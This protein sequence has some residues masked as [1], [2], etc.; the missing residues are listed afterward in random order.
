MIPLALAGNLSLTKHI[1]FI[2]G[3]CDAGD[4]HTLADIF[5][6]GIE[7]W[8][9]ERNVKVCLADTMEWPL[10]LQEYK[11]ALTVS[12]EHFKTEK[13][14]QIVSNVFDTFH[15]LL[16]ANPQTFIINK[17]ERL[18]VALLHVEHLPQTS[19]TYKHELTVWA[20][21]TP[22]LREQASPKIGQWYNLV[23]D[24]EM[25]RWHLLNLNTIDKTSYALPPD[26]TP[27]INTPTYC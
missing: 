1:D 7:K 15:H 10:W 11:Q 9:V 8:L 16:H 26:I 5:K 21:A 22:E 23:Q 24:E 17:P 4:F 25:L 6:S 27:E 14:A 18:Q 19:V 13:P 2:A 12:P 3:K 20:K